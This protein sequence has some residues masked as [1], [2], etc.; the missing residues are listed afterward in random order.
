MWLPD[1]ATAKPNSHIMMVV[2]L[3]GSVRASSTCRDAN[4]AHSRVVRSIG[5]LGS[6]LTMP[7]ASNRLSAGWLLHWLSSANPNGPSAPGYMTCAPDLA[8]EYPNSHI[9][10]LSESTVGFEAAAGRTSFSYFPQVSVARFSSAAGLMQGARQ[11][12]KAIVA[13]NFIDFS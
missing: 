10:V 12:P 5:F 9:T 13:N 2:A 7:S 4:T 3:S 1:L 11:T 6:G 8:T